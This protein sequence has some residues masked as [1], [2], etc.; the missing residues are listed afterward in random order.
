MTALLFAL[1]VAALDDPDFRVRE[2]ASLTAHRCV[3]RHPAAIGPALAL[4]C[5]T[6]PSA[7]ARSRLAR[8]TAPYRAYLA[9]TFVPTTVPCWPCVDQLPY[10]WPDDR[11][12]SSG[13]W[14]G[15]V[16]LEI[17]DATRGGPP[18]WWRWRRATEVMVRAQIRCGELTCDEADE[19]LARMWAVEDEYFE[20]TSPVAGLERATWR[21]W[22]GGYP[23]TNL[24]YRIRW[25][26]RPVTP[27]AI[28]PML[29]PIGP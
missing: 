10:D 23:P 21:G 20:R 5:H 9:D 15:R 8:L 17:P 7:E 27:I 4:L 18:Y 19:L 6:H 24:T 3:A 28:P 11:S 14:L 26:A 29:P 12:A 13:Y 16:P 25:G 2:W 22:A 1:A